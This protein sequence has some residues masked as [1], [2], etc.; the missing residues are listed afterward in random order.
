MHSSSVFLVEVSS[1]AFPYALLMGEKIKVDLRSLC[2]SVLIT[3]S[4]SY[5]MQQATDFS[6]SLSK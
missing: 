5:F 3:L 2:W 4:L 6:F 1:L